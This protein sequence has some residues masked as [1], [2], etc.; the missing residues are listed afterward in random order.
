MLLGD[1]H[2]E[3]YMFDDKYLKQCQNSLT[4][5]E[6]NIVEDPGVELVLVAQRFDL[7]YDGKYLP[8]IPQR[9]FSKTLMGKEWRVIPNITVNS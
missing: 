3:Q 8:T 1:I 2:I 5:F 9:C 6:T 7:F 4:V